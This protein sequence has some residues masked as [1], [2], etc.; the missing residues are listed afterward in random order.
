MSENGE[1]ARRFRDLMPF[2]ARRLRMKRYTRIDSPIGTLTLFSSDDSLSGLY[3][4]A[5]SKMPEQAG[6]DFDP[7]AP[8]L[9]EA[10]RQLDE[11]FGGRRQCFELPLTFRGT[12]FQQ[13]VWQALTQI[14]HGVT[15][16]YGQLARHIG[17][18]N[19]FRAVGLAN[20]RNPIA[21]IVPCHRVI[22]SDGSLTGFGGGLPRKEW[23]LRHEGGCVAAPAAAQVPMEFGVP[24]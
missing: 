14:P 24:A 3:M 12:P 8:V 19:G 5:P 9:R 15:W 20:G 22:G 16:S 11:Y 18:P 21:V 2:V 7:L 23:L 10:T 4:E 1:T 17:S 6:Y 13:R